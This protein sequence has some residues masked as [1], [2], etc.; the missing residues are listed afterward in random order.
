MLFL[1][2]NA[3]IFDFSKFDYIV[4]A[5]DTVTAKLAI[6]E[7]AKKNNVPVISAMGTGNKLNPLDLIITDISKPQCVRLLE[8][9]AQ[10]LEKEE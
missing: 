6:I 3:S 9:C 5:I 8:L 1:P 7:L 2:E 4:D 10:N